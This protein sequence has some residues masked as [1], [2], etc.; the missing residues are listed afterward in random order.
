MESLNYGVKTGLGL[1]PV[2]KTVEYHLADEL[3]KIYDDTAIE[4]I[5]YG[6]S[7]LGHEI[8]RHSDCTRVKVSTERHE[9][10]QSVLIAWNGPHLAGD[11]VQRI[12]DS[13]RIG[14]ESR[15]MPER[16]GTQIAGHWF[17]FVNGVVR[18]ENYK[19]G[20]Y[21]VRNVIEFILS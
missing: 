7:E 3:P 12:N 2:H 11:L 1:L 20:I 15:S 13:Y 14:A 10:T 4:Q 16:H 17:G 9:A 18:I 19:D 5:R 6:L 21:R 8:L